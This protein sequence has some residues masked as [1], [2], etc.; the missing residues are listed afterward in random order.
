M[1]GR[2]RRIDAR[3]EQ[4]LDHDEAFALARFAASLR[5]VEREAAG[6]VAAPARLGGRGEELADGVEEAGVGG[7]VRARRAS[8]RLLVDDHQPVEP[9]HSRDDAAAGGRGRRIL[10]RQLLGFVG[11]GRRAQAFGGQLDQRLADKARLARA[12][13]A[14]DGRE[15]AEREA[16]VEAAQVVARD[17][18][19]FEPA[20][21]G[22][23]RPG[24][25]A[26]LA[27]E[28]AP[29][30]R[31]L[32]R[33]QPGGTAAVEDAAAVLARAGPDVDDPV[34]GAHHVELV[35]DTKSELPA[36][37]EVARSARSSASVS[38]GCS[39]ADGSSST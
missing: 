28:V 13:N 14:G 30:L 2:T 16:D 10:D 21:R 27:E 22:P 11:G 26:L 32:H 29:G 4:Q 5:D 17:A 15:D 37:F 7:E 8:D 3:Q 18:V 19:Q 34:G 23:R 20:A 36:A 35:L 31:F 24:R 25:D 1:T 33:L 9:L 38:A 39:P 6:V 12:R